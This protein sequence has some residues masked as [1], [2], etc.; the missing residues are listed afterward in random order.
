MAQIRNRPRKPLQIR[1]RGVSARPIGVGP[2][3]DTLLF[4]N[5]RAVAT[6]A[7]I[8]LNTHSFSETKMYFLRMTQ[9]VSLAGIACLVALIACAPNSAIAQ[10]TE[11]TLKELQQ[12]WANIDAKLVAKE[13]ELKSAA[14]DD[15][16]L[17]KEFRDLVDEANAIV[18]KLESTAKSLL[19]TNPE[20][21]EAVRT[22][23]GIMVNDAQFNRDAKVLA[24]G[25]Q[26]IANGINPE[27]FKLASRSERLSIPAREIFDELMIRHAEAMKGDLPRVKFST[28]KGDIV[29][30]LY[31]NEAPNTVG[32]F[33]SLVEQDYYTDMIFHRVLEGFMAQGGGFKKVGDNEVGGEGPGYEIKCECDSPEKR[34]HFSNC[35]SMAHRGKDTGGSQFFLTF[36]RTDHLDGL[37]TC[38]GRVVEGQEV[39]DRLARTHIAGPQGEEPIPGVVKDKIIKAEVIRKRDHEYLPDKV[40]GN[41]EAE[42]KDEKKAVEPDSG[43]E[44][45]E[46]ANPDSDTEKNA[47]PAKKAESEKETGNNS[48]SDK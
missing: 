32:N 44:N 10:E 20:D 12:Q 7:G 38:F 25:D 24:M 17:Q 1:I 19:Q 9:Y 29:I 41:D 14:G 30:E 37:H 2:K 46:A 36:S 16:S 3:S 26:L 27:Y 34:L 8:E 40:G 48:E 42:K 15:E 39:L 6:L 11:T 22:M 43:E 4:E 33:V 23:M 31:E 5:N 21:P 28:T 45:A 47:E 35:L 18:E 13:T